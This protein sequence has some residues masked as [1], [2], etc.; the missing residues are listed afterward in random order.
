MH[1]LAPYV[2]L[3][4]ECT[5]PNSMFRTAGA[6]VGHMTEAHSKTTWKC[7]E[8]SKETTEEIGSSSQCVLRSIE[9]YKTHISATHPSSISDDHL[10]LLL[11]MDGRQQL[12]IEHCLFC[13]FSKQDN[14]PGAGSYDQS[15]FEEM[16]RHI[17]EEHLHG[18]AL[19]SLPWDTPNG[20]DLHSAKASMSSNEGAQGLSQRIEK[21]STTL[22]TRLI[23]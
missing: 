17:A 13:G 10:A 23:A 7:S 4:E 3:F 16:T 11:Q 6:W 9:D 12:R 19:L 2:C 21:A 15:G 8:C 22:Q 18:L 5:T 14:H 20:D 1:D